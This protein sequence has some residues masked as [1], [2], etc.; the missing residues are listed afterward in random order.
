MLILFKLAMETPKEKLTAEGLF[1]KTK[2]KNLE[3]DER[4][5]LEKLI[6]QMSYV[7]N[8]DFIDSVREFF[9]SNKGEIKFTGIFTASELENLEKGLD[10][11]GFKLTFSI[12]SSDDG[13]IQKWYKYT[14]R[15][16]ASDVKNFINFMNGGSV[17]FELSTRKESNKREDDSSK[18]LQIGA[19]DITPKQKKIDNIQE[20]LEGIK[21]KYNNTS[22]TQPEQSKSESQEEEVREQKSNQILQEALNQIK[23]IKVNVGG[24]QTEIG[25]IKNTQPKLKIL[26]Q[27]L[28]E[29]ESVSFTMNRNLVMMNNLKEIAKYWAGENVKEEQISENKFV[30]TGEG[31]SYEVKY[32]NGQYIITRLSSI[33][34]KETKQ[35]TQNVFSEKLVINEIDFNKVDKD[36]KHKVQK[37]LEG[38]EVEYNYKDFL[39]VKDNLLAEINKRTG[40]TYRYVEGYP[41]QVGTTNIH[42]VKLELVGDKKSNSLFTQPPEGMQKP[43]QNRDEKKDNIGTDSKK[44]PFQEIAL[45]QDLTSTVVDAL[46]EIKK[47]LNIKKDQKEKESSNETSKINKAMLNTDIKNIERDIK[48]VDRYMLQLNKFKEKLNDPTITSIQI[49]S[50][51]I[52]ITFQKGEPYV[53]EFIGSPFALISEDN[54]NKSKNDLIIQLK[55]M[56]IS[57]AES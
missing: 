42:R 13:Q 9:K 31:G 17:E 45:Y 25:S 46:G 15:E 2:L 6:Q 53:I 51:K 43:Q 29:G 40:R 10:K 50:N 3:K 5:A 35:E 47:E 56:Y 8:K 14:N 1:D 41:K 21:A 34:N 18:K 24:K 30:Y 37:L 32:E 26:E 22:S 57:F 27:G 4:N 12:I 19:L 48:S 52:T 38:K 36:G 49:S 54:L 39:N 23:D 20:D 33:Q 44:Q 28:K 7:N 16:P 55:K 11:L